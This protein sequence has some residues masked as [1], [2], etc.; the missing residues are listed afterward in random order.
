VRIEIPRR[1]T[2]TP[3]LPAFSRMIQ[4]V[5]MCFLVDDPAL[6]ATVTWSGGFAGGDVMVNGV[7]AGFDIYCHAPSSAGQLTIPAATLLALPPGGGKLIVL[8]ATAPQTVSATGLDLG[9]ATGVV[10]F[11]VPTSFK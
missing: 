10:S 6:D 1:R 7:S 11:N 2:F 9:L 3:A 5:N 4:T 8:N